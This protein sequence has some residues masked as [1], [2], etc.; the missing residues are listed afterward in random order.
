[1]KTRLF[2]VVTVLIAIGGICS[3]HLT[4]K[5]AS[6]PAPPITVNYHDYIDR[7]KEKL[8]NI[9]APPDGHY[10]VELTAKLKADGSIAQMSINSTPDSQQAKAAAKDALSRIQPLE[11]LPP[12][13]AKQA[14]LIMIF[15]SDVDPHGDTSL[16]LSI[17]LEPIAE[18][19]NIK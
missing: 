15:N 14:K 6:P 8:M 10:Q 16:N 12:Y 19:K 18:E 13:G 1:M 5:A 11:P 3:M 7:L 9:W 17:R 2:K 4:G